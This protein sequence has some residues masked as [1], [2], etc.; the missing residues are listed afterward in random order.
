M[1][2]TDLKMSFRLCYHKFNVVPIPDAFKKAFSSHLKLENANGILTYGYYD[3]SAGLTLEILASVE[4]VGSVTRII[5]H[6]EFMRLFMR[7][8]EFIGQEITSINIPYDDLKT[9]FHNKLSVV[10][11]YDCDTDLENVRQATALDTFRHE[12][13]IDDVMVIISKNN[14]RPEGCWVHTKSLDGLYFKGILLN[15]PN[16]D[17]GVHEGDYVKFLPVM[18]DSENLILYCDLA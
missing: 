8:K 13:C 2:L 15:E 16:Q 10:K 18:I 3:E 14:L 1:K 17:F 5:E 6:L 11:H 4:T 9:R 12:F 7:I